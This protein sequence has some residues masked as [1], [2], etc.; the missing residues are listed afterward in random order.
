MKIYIGAD[1]RGFELKENLKQWM[2]QS[3][4]E[5]EDMGAS[6]LNPL[7]DF[8]DYA[9]AVAEK[10]AADKE[11]RGIVICGSGVGVDVTANKIKGILCGLGFSPEQV[12]SATQHDH[13][14]VLALPAA[15]INQQQAETIVSTFLKTPYAQ[16]EKYLRRVKKIRQLET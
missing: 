8:A 14:N 13:I 1:H 7:D 4:L 9:K 2:L 11:S 6:S 12:L 5:F 10:V 16:D 15:H 3:N